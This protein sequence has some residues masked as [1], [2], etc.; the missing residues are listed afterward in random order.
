MRL[1]ELLVSYK[2]LTSA[3]HLLSEGTTAKAV[4]SD[5]NSQVLVIKKPKEKINKYA[6]KN[7]VLNTWIIWLTYKSVSVHLIL[8]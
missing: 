5:G 3:F 2:W 1:N 7:F 8:A 4:P 6:Q